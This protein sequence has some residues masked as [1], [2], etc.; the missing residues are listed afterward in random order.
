MTVGAWLR[1]RIVADCHSTE[2]SATWSSGAAAPDWA[3]TLRL[4]SRATSVRSATDQRSVTG[5]EESPSRNRAVSRPLSA[6]CS[7]I[8]TSWLETPARRGRG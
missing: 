3:Y 2:A 5:I 6:V 7:E 1:R 8:V 4:S